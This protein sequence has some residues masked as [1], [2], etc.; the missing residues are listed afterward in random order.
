MYNAATP[1]RK[2]F[3]EAL[4]DLGRKNS[5]IVVLTAD[6]SDAIKVGGFR[7]EFPDRFY[8]M[9]IKESDMM[10]TA[11]G[12][13]MD[14]KIPFATTFAVFATSL[15]NQP[16]RVSV[17][18]N[19][20]NV[21][22]A[23]SHGGVCVG[24]DGATH[25]AFEDIA[26]MRMLPGM[27]VLVPADANAA[28]RAVFAAAEHE[29]PVYLRLGRVPTPVVQDG[30]FRIGEGR[31]LRKGGDVAIVACGM[32]VP[33]AL[34]AADELSRQDIDA[35]V[36]DMYSIKPMDI[37]LLDSAAKECGAI[38]TAEE[39]SILGGLGG[40][41]AEH[42]TS[43]FPVPIERVGVTDTFGESGEPAEILEKYG[44]TRETIVDKA[45]RCLERKISRR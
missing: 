39:H 5:N 36:I 3:G 23:T 15:A 30:D 21:K 28:Y 24:G 8:Q 44:L 20:A 18:Y 40:A 37:E 16:V 2:A 38:V 12:M 1:M 11:A 14:G 41:V 43:T 4:I 31:I 17:A 13:A 33:M 29:G 42:L 9:G 26:L 22:I 32:M 7:D 35:R 45:K 6:L 19:Q 25:Q 27:T 10:G 34:E